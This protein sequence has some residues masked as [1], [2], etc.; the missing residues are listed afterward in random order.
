MASLLTYLLLMA[1]PLITGTLIERSH[2]KSIRKRE[3]DLINTP[4]LN[5]DC[6]FS[7]LD[8]DFESKLVSGSVVL[9]ADKFKILLGALRSFFGGPVSAFETLID[10]ARRES[11]LRLR[12]KALGCDAIVNLRLETSRLGKNKIEVF[13]YAVAIYHTK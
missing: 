3:A 12:E 10:R 11:I 13:A 1:V 8:K 7:E 9:A 5:L 6:G 4:L 2:Y